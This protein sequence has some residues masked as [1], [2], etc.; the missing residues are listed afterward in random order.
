MLTVFFVG[1]VEMGPGSSEG[2]AH[3]VA[4]RVCLPSFIPSAILRKQFKGTF[5]HAIKL[6][7]DAGM[8]QKD[9][10]AVQLLAYCYE[11][12]YCV[13]QHRKMFADLLKYARRL[14]DRAGEK[15]PEFEPFAALPEVEK[16]PLA[17]RPPFVIGGTSTVAKIEDTH[18]YSRFS[19]SLTCSG[20]GRNYGPT[21]PEPNCFREGPISSSTRSETLARIDTGLASR[22]VIPSY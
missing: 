11:G 9:P 21:P 2:R 1:F 5:S 3:L 19:L 6:L 17:A 10:E 4:A 20:F 8:V 12:G 7:K 16:M 13:V 15:L 14:A 22:L 18:E